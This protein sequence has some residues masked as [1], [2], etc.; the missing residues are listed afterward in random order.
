M[1]YTEEYREHIEYTFHAYCKIVIYHA[2]ID[3]ARQRHRRCEKEISLEYL[4]EEKHYPLSTID[5][6]FTVPEQEKY[7]LHLC[8]QEVL[9]HHS[10]LAAALRNNADSVRLAGEALI[11]QNTAASGGGV[12]LSGTDGATGMF[13]MDGVRVSDN[14]AGTT[15]G[16]LCLRSGAGANVPQPQQAEGGERVALSDAHPTR[17]GYLFAGWNTEPNESGA[18][19]RPGEPF[20]PIFADAGPY[21]RWEALPPIGHTLTYCGNDAGCRPVFCIPCPQQ[22][23]DGQSIQIPCHAPYRAGY[24][25]IGWNTDPYGNGRMVYPGQRF[26]PMTGDACLYARWRS[27]PPPNPLGIRC[28]EAD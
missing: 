15:G 24:C 3:A 28:R 4:T 26:G 14:I 9:F 21:A 19:Y 10:Q 13:S 17:V 2:A 18:S 22:V 27:L 5:E 16:G 1:T 12:Y 23:F 20:G 7:S 25:F 8:G 6:Y 11:E